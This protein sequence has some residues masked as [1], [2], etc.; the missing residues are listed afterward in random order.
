MDDVA[1][2]GLVAAHS[3]P[4]ATADSRVLAVPAALAGCFPD[5][6]IRRGSTV[7]I[8]PATG[9]VSLALA[10]TAAA[11][12]DGAWAAAVAL[13][14]LGLL[15]A[16]ELGVRL[17]RMALVP[18]PSDRWPAV[19]AALLDGMDLLLLGPPAR[20][21][22]ADARRLM[23]RAREQGTVLVVL[24]PP[25]SRHWP[26]AADLRLTI[27]G[28]TWEGL[29]LGYGHLQ[30]RRVEVVVTGRRAATRE[31]RA[32]M[33]LPGQWDHPAPDRPAV[34]LPD[35]LSAARVG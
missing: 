35:P 26:E 12:G 10:L 2:L 21:R 22:S 20:V 34:P 1:S 28:A 6:G 17:E 30:S 7:V 19:V 4:V 29:G 23:A 31:R 18:A 5:G 8:G 16:A 27:A 25:G 14:S 13:P 3:R 32:A 33:W 24:D 11:V 15:A 9:G